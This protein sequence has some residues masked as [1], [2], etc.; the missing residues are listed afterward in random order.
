MINF[1]TFS[2]EKSAEKQE[3]EL[4]RAYINEV[5]TES[6]NRLSEYFPIFYRDIPT[7]LDYQD[8]AE[9]LKINYNF[10]GENL[11]INIR[12]PENLSGKTVDDLKKLE[13]G[14]LVFQDV[15]KNE[16]VSKKTQD[17]FFLSHEYNHRI[18]QVVLKEYRP[19][20]IQITEGKRKEFAEADES[21]K[22]ELKGEEKNSIFP[23]L[24]E[25]MPISL[26]RIIVEKILQ[27]GNIDDNEK[28]NAKKFW[29]SHKRSLLS[30]R[31]E[32][33][34]KSKYSE[35]DEA[36]IYY[37]IY[38]EFGE[39]GIIDFIK[40]F[41]FGKLSRIRKYSDV[42]NRILSE[43]YKEFLEMSASEISH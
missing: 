37:K 34:P 27:D 3:K 14:F 42:E 38:Q 20:I 24:G 32:E 41:D 2:I 23:V 16:T 28:N 7:N 29:E 21:K 10:E 40:N 6:K 22:E 5:L 26:E 1:E 39:K 36:M 15:A 12:T 4:Q 43:E 31:L 11:N 19:D 35:L 25:S 13:G 33:D 30:K 18:N 8:N 9:E 17:F